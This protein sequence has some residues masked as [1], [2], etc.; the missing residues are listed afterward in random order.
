VLAGI[1]LER[2]VVRAPG[3]IGAGFAEGLVV[4]SAETGRYFGFNRT[5]EAI[6]E[7][8]A[9]PTTVREI[10]DALLARFDATP[11]EVTASLHNVLSTLSEHHL[12]A[13]PTGPDAQ[14]SG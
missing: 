2:R 10:R 11:D 8:L 4:L 5:A 9:Q 13:P 12:L 6:W 14:V 7:L 1:D 3:P